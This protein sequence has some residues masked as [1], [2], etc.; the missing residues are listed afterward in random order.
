MISRSILGASVLWIAA[1]AF[2]QPWTPLIS[3]GAGAAI[4]TDAG[5]SQ[6][7]PAAIPGVFEFYNYANDQKTQ[8][9]PVLDG[10]VGA[11]WHKSPRVALQLGLDY[12]QPAPYSVNGTLT[13][14]LDAQSAN[15]YTYHYNVS[16][17]QLL[18][19]SKLLYMGMGA[20]HP[21][22]LAGLGAAFNTANTYSTNVPYTESFTRAYQDHTTTAWSYALGTGLDFD[23]TP[24]IR[25]GLG[26][27]FADL[28]EVALGAGT[29]NDVAVTG[30]LSQ[31][32]LYTN[33]I[34][35]QL[36]ALF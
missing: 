22:L 27:R 31:T 26:Y 16:S 4:I 20:F 14:G 2:A 35:A 9:P 32:H 25:F 36:T 12:N 13:Q 34:L 5:Q 29:I 30:T 21:Y 1:S 15:T 6:N 28:G 18:V 19:E 8:T 24:H 17:Q 10:F 23:I 3:L 11:E 7:F 33:E